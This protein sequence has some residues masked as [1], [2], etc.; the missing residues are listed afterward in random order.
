MKKIEVVC[1]AWGESWVL[2]TLADNGVHLL[3]EYSPEAL[4]RG[5]EFSP[6]NLKL[7]VQAY[8]DFPRHQHR[9]PGLLADSLPDG[10]GMLLMDRLI[11]QT[12]KSREQISPLDRL[13]MMGDRTMG[14]FSFRPPLGDPIKPAEM[15]LLTLANEVRQEMYGQDSEVLK[16]L[17]MIGGS[18]HGARPKALVQY[19][20]ALAQVS[21]LDTGLGSPWLIKF[22]AQNEH[23]EVC[24]IEDVYAAMARACQLDVPKTH[25]FDLD[26]SL[27]S[28]GIERFDRANGLRVPIH[29]LAGLLNADFRVPSMGYET[30]LRATTFITR[31]ERELEKAFERCVFNVIFNNRDDH[32]KNF[33][34]RM[35]E[36]MQWELAPCYDLTYNEGPG[37]EHQ[38]DILGEGRAPS[39]VHLI[40][41]AKRNGLKA[42][43]ASQVIDRI[44]Q[45]A[46]TFSGIAKNH[47]I[48]KQTIETI[49]GAI[50]KN[51]RRMTG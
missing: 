22:Q 48:R 16:E 29:S 12:G 14:A 1:G 4:S 6:R 37:G 43:W 9:L 39:K 7:R 40:E 49:A 20:I 2:G 45:V 34:F 25:Y 41:L 33:S 50:E 21:T 27:A 38:M 15:S 47:A 17:M 18:P 5:V 24:A 19:D 31:S 44:S 8:G 11:N 36:Q 42:K 46:E 26:P 28:F 13:G 51:R 10:W 3:F 30:L 35:N 32:A 23:K